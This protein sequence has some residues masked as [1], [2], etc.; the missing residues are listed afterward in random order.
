LKDHRPVE[1]FRLIGR[2]RAMKALEMSDVG[3]RVY[4][5]LRPVPEDVRQHLIRDFRCLELV[6]VA[7]AFV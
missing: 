6:R 4:A 7:V 3:F 5:R 1:A 2:E